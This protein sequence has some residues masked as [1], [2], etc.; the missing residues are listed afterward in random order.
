M[1]RVYRGQ[2]FYEEAN[3]YN[4]RWDQDL[5]RQFTLT[6]P[7]TKAFSKFVSDFQ[8]DNDLVIDGK[9]G[10]NTLSRLR[11][12]YFD[13]K[14]RCCM[15]DYLNIV[16]VTSRFEGKFWTVNRD[17]EF[18]GLF[19]RPGKPH[20]ASGKIHIGLSY[21]FIQFTQ[22]SGT[23][24]KVL[25]RMH[26]KDPKRFKDIF[27]EF[28]NQLLEVTNRSGRER[29]NGRSPR[30][31]PVGGHDLW[32]DYWVRRFIQAGRHTPFQEAQM[33]AAI[34]LYMKPAIK[35]AEQF[36]ISSE[37][38][39]AMVF[40][41]TVHYGPRGARELIQKVRGDDPEHI[42]LKR[43]LTEWSNRRWSHRVKK[44]FYEPSLKDSSFSFT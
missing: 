43:L 18:K 25:K 41:R 4:R 44:I 23:L 10:P 36:N 11:Q 38:G 16:R 39:L 22:D 35:T 9:L 8:K 13:N 32:S 3:A 14:A 6:K 12:S 27:G 29:T 17:G 28:S 31:Q 5:V 42:F 33:E 34:E 24:G 15:S 30:V 40:D 19:D 1:S 21:G 2:S 26:D 20:W 7:G 37:R